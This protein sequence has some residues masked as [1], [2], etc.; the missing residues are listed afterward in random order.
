VLEKQNSYLPYPKMY[1]LLKKDGF[2]P[3]FVKFISDV[4][5]YYLK[6]IKLEAIKEN[7]DHQEFLSLY[8]T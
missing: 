8:S 5:R 6:E 7:A 1:L 2:Y 4:R 3:R